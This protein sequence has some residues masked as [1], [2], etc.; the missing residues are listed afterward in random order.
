MYGIVIEKKAGLSQYQQLY[1]QLREQIVNGALP[2]HTKIESTRTMASEL[3][4]SRSIVLEVID[5]LKVEGY[6]D[7]RHGSGTYVIPEISLQRDFQ[8]NLSRKKNT[9]KSNNIEKELLSF[10]AGIPD[11]S[12]F[13][14]RIWNRMYTQAVEYA[15]K[16]DFSYNHPKGRFDL[17]EALCEY[18]YRTKGIKTSTSN[19]FLTAGS[20]QAIAV[21]TELQKNSRIV[22]EDP[23]AGFIYEI[24]QS[25]NCLITTAEVDE[26]GI[27]PHS[28][29]T[30]EQNLLYLSPSHQYPLGGSLPAN[31]R[32]EILKGAQQSGTY[33]IEDDYDG[34]YRFDSRPIAPLQ[35]LA[36]ERV[37]YLGTFSKILSPALR[38]GYMVVPDELIKPFMKIKRRWDFLN[39]GLNQ[40]AMARFIRDGHM[41]RHLRKSLKSYGIKKKAIELKVKE[42]LGANW[43]ISGNTTGLHMIIRLPG[44][45]FTGDVRNRMIENGILFEPVSSYSINTINHRDKLV[46]GYGHRTIEEVERGLVKLQEI[47]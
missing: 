45:N 35:V 42:I 13:P 34:E 9:D 21:I 10:I 25:K 30:K 2:Q 4:I 3:K 14:R 29:S 38:L 22:M 41:Y 31:R 12:L 44:Y 46:L 16:K 28:F 20:A 19:I 47:L 33:I 39:E 37:I 1:E 24:I 23:S 7:T 5:Q 8:N 27:I 18:L 17:R 43:E 15:D 6:L 36:P 40:M 26:M 11:L 32:V